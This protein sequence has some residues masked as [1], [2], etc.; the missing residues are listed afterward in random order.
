[1]DIK[2]GVCDKWG[3]FIMHDCSQNEAQSVMRHMNQSDP[4]REWIMIIEGY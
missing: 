3:M 1:M 2:Y 4:S